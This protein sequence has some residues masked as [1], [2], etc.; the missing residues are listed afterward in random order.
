M[1]GDIEQKSDESKGE[2]MGGRSARSVE[3]VVSKAGNAF[4]PYDRFPWD[5][6]VVISSTLGSTLANV[7][8]V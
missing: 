8:F 5:I 7:A 3:S 4:W 2:V 6:D 1:V